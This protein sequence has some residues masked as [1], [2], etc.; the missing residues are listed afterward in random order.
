MAPAALRVIGVGVIGCGYWGPKLVRNF[1]HHERARVA[2]VCDAR[3]ER[4]AKVAWE[5][6]VDSVGDDPSEV[7]AHPD[8][9]LVV[10]ATPSRTHYSLARA[11]LEAGKHVLVTKPMTTRLDE[12]E[13]LVDLADRLGL[14]LAVD[15]T[16]VYSGAVRAMRALV[17][18]GEIGDVYYIDSVRINLGVFQSDINVLWDLAPHDLSIIDHLMGAQL[19]LEVSAVAAAHAGSRVEDIAYLTMR[20]G[21]SVLAHVH[22]NWLAPAKIRRTIVGGSRRML[23][24]DDVQP[25]EKLLIYDKGVSIAPWDDPEQIYS[26]LVSYRSGDMRAPRLDDREPLAVE[27]DH[28]IG[29]LLEGGDPIADGKAGLRT[30]RIL[31][32]AEQSL[33]RHSE[34][35][36]V[37][38][39]LEA[40]RPIPVDDLSAV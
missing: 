21:P 7:I 26:Q 12:A 23:V 1:A 16:F 9:D 2:A 32:A 8:V 28:L 31:E 20:Y 27:V 40:W 18:S 17:E 13:E 15:H 6:R 39:G 25:S 24:Y 22:V 29:C 37:D 33:R 5:F 38:R 11:A 14:M 30:V 36:A 4:A 35:V 19:P 3:V 10:V 34:P